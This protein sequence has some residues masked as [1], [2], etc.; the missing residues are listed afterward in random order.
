[1][2]CAVLG[3][4]FFFQRPRAELR[5]SNS[6][7]SSFLLGNS[8]IE[9]YWT[10]SSVKFVYG[11]TFSEFAQQQQQQRSF[12]VHGLVNFSIKIS[13][14]FTLKSVHCII[15]PSSTSNRRLYLVECRIIISY[16]SSLNTQNVFGHVFLGGHHKDGVQGKAVLASGLVC[17]TPGRTSTSHSPGYKNY[18]PEREAGGTNE[19]FG[20]GLHDHSYL[21]PQAPNPT[22]AAQHSARPRWLR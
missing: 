3:H 14:K 13:R 11:S 6:E 12:Q 22:S 8:Q 9:K 4:P 2:L 1:M 5:S 20:T 7:N 10:R 17:K 15:L 19:H 18:T 16:I 21:P